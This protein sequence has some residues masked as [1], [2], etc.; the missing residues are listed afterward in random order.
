MPDKL[1]PKYPD[2][3]VTLTGHDGNAMSII[4]TV[5]SVLR[6]GGVPAAEITAFSNEAMGGD[7]D[8]VLATAMR[9][10]TVS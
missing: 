2:I 9:W 10:V 5:R 6:A 8:N 1:D 4:G 7:Y 3:E